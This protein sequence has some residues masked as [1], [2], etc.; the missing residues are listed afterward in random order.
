MRAAVVCLP[1]GVL[2]IAVGSTAPA[3]ER[4][5]QLEAHRHGQGT[6]DVAIEGDR[7]VM[8]LGA[9]GTDIVG[10]EHEPATEAETAATDE[11]RS[12]LREPLTLFGIPEAAGCRAESVEVVR[13]EEAAHAEFHGT[14][15][16][17]CRSIEDLI[18]MTLRY[19]EAF[20]AAE[21]LVVSVVGP[22][23]Q[24]RYFLDRSNPVIDLS[25]HF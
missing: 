24:S 22:R 10:F 17:V 5:P 19:F 3:E 18:R 25:T 14:Y 16:L 15:T 7:M 20:P 11:A 6:L 1:A 13:T 4:H 12:L 23:S 21:E 2:M 9:P 8:E